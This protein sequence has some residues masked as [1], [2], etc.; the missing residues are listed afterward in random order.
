MKRTFLRVNDF[1]EGR[2]RV[3][4]DAIQNK[5]FPGLLKQ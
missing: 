4:N 2:V 3:E 1:L 5:K